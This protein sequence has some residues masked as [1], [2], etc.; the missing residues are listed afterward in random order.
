MRKCGI[1]TITSDQ[2]YGNC[3]QNYALQQ[4]VRRCGLEPETIMYNAVISPGE[5]AGNAVTKKLGEWR[6]AGDAVYDLRR[7]LRKRLNSR[8]YTKLEQVR[9]DRF[10]AFTKKYI[11]TSESVYGASDDLSVLDAEYDVFLAGSDQIWNPFYEGSDPFYFLSF[12]QKRKRLTYASSFGVT[13]IPPPQRPYYAARLGEL[14]EV[15]VREERGRELVE[16]LTG[17]SARVMPDPTML[18][19]RDEWLAVSK[20]AAARPGG[21]YLLA[22]FLGKDVYPIRRHVLKYADSLRLPV[23]TLNNKRDSRWYASGPAEFLDLFDNATVICTDSYHGC[24]FSL[25]FNR[26]FIVFDRL[27]PDKERS[28][29][30]RIDTLAKDFNILFASRVIDAKEAYALDFGAVNRIIEKKREAAFN[31]LKE[32]FDRVRDDENE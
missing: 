10:A 17:K 4:A 13:D 16:E 6:S 32:S 18:L 30:S 5:S 28:M 15:S 3:L 27:G 19:T 2:N 26:P 24:V 7:I 31:Y 23:V 12:A 25:I 22:Y 14:G 11:R 9:K 20:K 8:L 1:A 29:N 21:K